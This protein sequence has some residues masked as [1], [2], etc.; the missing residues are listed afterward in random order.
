MVRS[1]RFGGVRRMLAEP[2][3]ISRFAGVHRR[4]VGLP[5]GGHPQDGP[6][7]RARAAEWDTL[8]M[9]CA[10][11]GTEGS[12]PSASALAVGFSPRA[13]GTLGRFAAADRWYSRGRKRSFEQN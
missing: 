1:G 7:K 5:A 11:K 3:L 10:R 9:C 2:P 4:Q 13:G 12:N 8:L 6:G